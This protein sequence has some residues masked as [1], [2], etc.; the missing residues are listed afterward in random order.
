MSNGKTTNTD[1]IDRIDHLRLEV[2][3][4][5]QTAITD[6]KKEV[7]ELRG[8]FTTLEAGRLT[9]LEKRMNDFVVNNTRQEA[10]ITTKFFIL[11]TIAYV[12][13]FVILQAITNKWIKP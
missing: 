13:L 10:T 9:A 1:I 6:L 4:D 8:N 12:V 11:Q 3:S 5:M 7:A 2:K